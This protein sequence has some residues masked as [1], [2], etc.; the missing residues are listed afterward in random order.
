MPKYRIIHYHDKAGTVSV[1][2][3]VVGDAALIDEWE[4]E[5]ADLSDAQQ[6]VLDNEDYKIELVKDRN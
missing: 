2:G 4:I 3:E 1:R 6:I 5:A